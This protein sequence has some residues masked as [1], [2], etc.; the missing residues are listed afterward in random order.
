MLLEDDGSGPGGDEG[1]SEGGEVGG[2]VVAI[3]DRENFLRWILRTQMQR[4]Q[5]KCRNSD[6]VTE[7]LLG[8]SLCPC[9]QLS[10]LTE[11]LFRFE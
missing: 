2:A 1:G 3:M 6:R 7:H 4:G 10:L 9:F 5:K 11:D 8:G